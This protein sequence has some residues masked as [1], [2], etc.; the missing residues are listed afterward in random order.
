MFADSW[1][2]HCRPILGVKR[3]LDKGAP[4]YASLGFGN[5]K[6]LQTIIDGFRERVISSSETTLEPIRIT[7]EPLK[8]ENEPDN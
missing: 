5:L 6:A 2:N 1:K 7:H 4:R 3:A 8:E